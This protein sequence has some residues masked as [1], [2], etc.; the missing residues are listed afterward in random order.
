MN[1]AMLS[2]RQ[3]KDQFWLNDVLPFG[4]EFLR[5]AP[6]RHPPHPRCRPS[7]RDLLRRGACPRAAH[8]AEPGAPHDDDYLRFHHE[9]HEVITATS[10]LI[11]NAGF[12][13]QVDQPDL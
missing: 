8:G 5:L 9:R 6:D 13:L 10:A 11:A 4:N 12:E 1:K 2:D 7:W 3:M